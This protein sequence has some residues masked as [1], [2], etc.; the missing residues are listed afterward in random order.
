MEDKLE[1]ENTIYDLLRSG[2]E[3]GDIVE[4]IEQG[5]VKMLDRFGRDNQLPKGKDLDDLLNQLEH[6]E[7]MIWFRG[8][9]SQLSPY[10]TDGYWQFEWPHMNDYM[11]GVAPPILRAWLVDEQ[12]LS[13]S[14]SKTSES[15][16]KTGT[17]LADKRW[18]KHKLLCE[19]VREMAIPFI[20]RGKLLHN[21]I[22]N[23]LIN[24][25]DLGGLSRTV[26]IREVASQ[27]YKMNRDD[28]IRGKKKTK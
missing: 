22:A 23:E 8:V 16:S 25:C 24:T 18:A 3:V 6:H 14:K 21:V 1:S 9:P 12:K 28:L 13:T 26:V 11:P 10:D 27:C 7:H 15:G 19:K 17:E 2:Y 5:K 4:A 20:N